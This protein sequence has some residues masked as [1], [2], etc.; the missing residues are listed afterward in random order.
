MEAQQEQNREQQQEQNREQVQGSRKP[1]ARKVGLQ[2]KAGLH[3]VFDQR[4]NGAVP[5]V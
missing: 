2:L 1:V 4:Q 3:G 5:L